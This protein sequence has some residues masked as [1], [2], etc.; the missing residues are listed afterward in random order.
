[1]NPWACTTNP[2]KYAYKACEI[3]GKKTK[4]HKEIL[5]VLRTIDCKK[6][7]EVEKQ[8]YTPQVKNK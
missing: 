7:N 4:N 2:K 8:L 5:E 3:L 6:L 1:M